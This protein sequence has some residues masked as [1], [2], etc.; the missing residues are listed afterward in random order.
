[1]SVTHEGGDN[2]TA[3]NVEVSGAGIASS[4]CDGDGTNVGTSDWPNDEI[5]AGDDCDL[6]G[7]GPNSGE[8]LRLIWSSEGGGSSST[9]STYEA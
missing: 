4:A 6:A 3:T 9:L 5:S 2:V 1:V 8:T 7:A